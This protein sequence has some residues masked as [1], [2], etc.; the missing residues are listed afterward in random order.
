[1]VAT[2]E[3]LYAGRGRRPGPGATPAEMAPPV[4]VFLVGY[5]DE[6]PVA[7]GG[8]RRLEP[9]VAEIKR[10]YVV[11]DARGRGIARAL[12]TALE[13]AARELGY[14]RVRLDTGPRQP[15][16]RALYESV[17]YTEVPDYNAN[18][19]AAFWG[20]KAL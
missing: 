16:A 17:G 2:L 20:G 13:E 6:R 4:G 8:V 5:D 7:C 19:Y 18:P 10:M 14:E 12:L 11:P 3:E 15:H 1:M 9:G